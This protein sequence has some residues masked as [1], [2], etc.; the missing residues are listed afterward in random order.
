MPLRVLYRGGNF[1]LPLGGQFYTARDKASKGHRADATLVVIFPP[2]KVAM[3]FP[4]WTFP[5][6]ADHSAL[7]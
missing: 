5:C 4:L 7:F 3:D 2:K 6:S 1:I